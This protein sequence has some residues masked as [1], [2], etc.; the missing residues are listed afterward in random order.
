MRKREVQGGRQGRS[1][2]DKTS[3]GSYAF[4]V[5]PRIKRKKTEQMQCKKLL[6]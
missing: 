2:G 4:M 5:K 1:Q 3:G 6:Y